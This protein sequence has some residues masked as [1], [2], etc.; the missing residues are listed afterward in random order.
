[1][2][3]KSCLYKSKIRKQWER[4]RVIAYF[5]VFRFALFFVRLR[6]SSPGCHQ[7]CFVRVLAS[8]HRPLS[9]MRSSPIENRPEAVLVLPVL[10]R[11]R[12]WPLPLL[13]FSAPP[14]PVLL[15]RLVSQSHVRTYP[16]SSLSKVFSS[17]LVLEEEIVI[18]KKKRGFV[19]WMNSTSRITITRRIQN[20]VSWTHCI[21][22]YYYK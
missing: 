18:E 5:L 12:H 19:K 6:G 16:Y 13:L 3:I 21:V 1:M 17:L 10:W 15:Q 11:E 20:A 14:P 4:K 2:A 8:S 9:S 22:K 7:R